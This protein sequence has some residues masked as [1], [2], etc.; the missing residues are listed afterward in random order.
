[1]NKFILATALIG[2][3]Y[4]GMVGCGTKKTTSSSIPTSF[5]PAVKQAMKAYQNFN[6]TPF[7]TR[8]HSRANPIVKVRFDE[9]YEYGE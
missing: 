6:Q 5:S 4:L 8:T 9:D 3:I 1:M 2:I 7:V